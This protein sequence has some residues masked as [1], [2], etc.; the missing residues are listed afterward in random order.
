MHLLILSEGKPSL[1]E[2]VLAERSVRVTLVEGTLATAFD[3]VIAAEPTIALVD[4]EGDSA[5]FLMQLAQLQNRLPQCIVVPIARDP[6]PAFLLQLIRIG[7][8]DVLTEVS[9]AM[10]VELVDRIKER[11]AREVRPPLK[12]AK[13]LA[14]MSVKGGSGATLLVTNLA[15]ALGHA[16]AGR[17]V[18][19]MDA[20]LPFGDADIY[21]NAAEGE[22]HLGHFHDSIERLDDALFGAMVRKIGTNLDFIAAPPTIRDV[23]SMEPEGVSAL[24]EKAKL[25]YDYILVDMSSFINNFTNCVL[26]SVDK[27]HI[28]SLG[29][30]VDIKHAVQIINFLNDIKFPEEKIVLC[31][32]RWDKA[33]VITVGDVAQA[34]GKDVSHIIPEARSIIFKSISQGRSVIDIAP[35]SQF[36]EAI[37]GWV[38]EITG[39]SQKGKSLWTRLRSR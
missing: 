35:K 12:T 24:I 21:L 22:H 7:I 19:L 2:G 11:Q 34:T 26:D 30:I 18:L 4:C 33:D 5:V 20:A 39:N 15:I 14:V 38:S 37:G 31:L 9:T 3:R 23:V 27:L 32:N 16:A 13:C 25:I 10:T 6:D 28:I 17:R 29:S 1:D 36:S 8:P